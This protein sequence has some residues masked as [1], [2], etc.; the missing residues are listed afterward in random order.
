MPRFVGHDIHL[1]LAVRSDLFLKLNVVGAALAARP[2]DD[3]DAALLDDDLRAFAGCQRDSIEVLLSNR[4][5]AL[6]RR[7]GV[8]RRDILLPRFRGG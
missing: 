7:A 1:L 2:Y 5:V 3:V 6:D 4:Q 8:E